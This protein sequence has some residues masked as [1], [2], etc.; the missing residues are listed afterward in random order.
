MACNNP[1][2]TSSSASAPPSASAAPT[3]G[4]V[5]ARVNGVPITEEDVTLRSKGAPSH[6]SVSV[7]SPSKAVLETVIRDEL[8]YQRA[9]ELGLDHDPGY[10]KKVAE[11]EAQLAAF[12][13]REMVDTF[14][15]VEVTGKATVTDAEAK[16]YFDAHEKEIKAE[17][18][19]MQILINR[20]EDAALDISVQLK[21]GADFEELAKKRFPNLPPTI[22]APWDLGFLRWNQ[23][24]DAWSPAVFDLKPGATTGVISGEG[25]RFWILKLVER[26]DLPNASFEEMKP[27][28]EAVL[29]REKIEQRRMSVFDDLK[30]KAKI[31]YTSAAPAGS[32][33]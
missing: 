5:L 26:R 11:M 30:A 1:P 28:I 12:K 9:K 13:R 33:Q 3:E 19:V 31:E 14:N 6:G 23:I 20:D 15:R 17:L 7:G 22:K 21:K 25:G 29:K 24:P 4:K 32:A 16:A 2:P 10:V 27:R 8:V 18:H